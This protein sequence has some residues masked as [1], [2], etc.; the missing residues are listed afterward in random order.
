MENQQNSDFG[1][2]RSRRS[3]TSSLP[4][5]KRQ[6][7]WHLN[8]ARPDRSGWRFARRFQSVQLLRRRDAIDE[9]ALRSLLREAGPRR[10]KRV[11]LCDQGG[12]R[13]LPDL[14]RG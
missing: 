7:I 6:A 12:G 2:R 1:L 4:R 9:T 3:C 8:P 14:V 10:T 5:R 13:C 11:E